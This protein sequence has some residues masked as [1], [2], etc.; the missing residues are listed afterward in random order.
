M[1]TVDYSPIFNHVLDMQLSSQPKK[2]YQINEGS[3]DLP[4]QGRIDR[5]MNVLALPDGSGAT[6]IIRRDELRP[7]E[8]LL[9]FAERQLA[10]LAMQ[11]KGYQVVQQPSLL[12]PMAGVSDAL[13][14]AGAFTQ[15]DQ[16]IHQR[17]AALQLAGTSRVLI[18]TMSGFEPFDSDAIEAWAKVV[19][20]FQL[21]D[22]S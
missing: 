7:G 11:V 16:G 17:Q 13:E 12:S 18:V 3:I 8:A 9:Q 22:K 4:L 1:R 10:D 20:S 21:R 5:T 15:N 6:Y 14:F 19:R 2:H